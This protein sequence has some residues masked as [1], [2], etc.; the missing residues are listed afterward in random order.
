MKV[1]G[2]VKVGGVSEAIPKYRKVNWEQKFNLLSWKVCCIQ[3]HS[4]EHCSL[5]I[6]LILI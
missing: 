3:D 6:A 1:Y 4:P 5:F 2:E